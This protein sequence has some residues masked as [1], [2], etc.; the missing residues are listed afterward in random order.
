MVAEQNVNRS[1]THVARFR[2]LGFL[3]ALNGGTRPETG[4]F[5]FRVEENAEWFVIVP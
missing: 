5:G 4:N 1:V 3:M 2:F